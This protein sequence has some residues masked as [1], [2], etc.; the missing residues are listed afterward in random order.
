MKTIEKTICSFEELNEKNKAKAIEKTR[1]WN[2]DDSFWHEWV[3][4]DATEI[5]KL[6]GID[7]GEIYFSGFWSQGDGACFVGSFS[8]KKGMMK[9]VK[10]YAPQDTELHAIAKDIQELHRKAFYRDSGRIT[11]H[12]NYSH[13]RSM[14]VNS[15]SERDD[16][17]QEVFA[18]LA[19]WIY[20]NLKKEYEYQ[21]SDEAISHSLIANEVEFQLGEDGKIEF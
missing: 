1:D 7:M 6:L 20:R 11:H 17:W 4:E 15:D 8:H 3:I 18:D 14:T 5:G 9:T 16:E 2:T 13:E 12:G 19:L 21:Q 10:E